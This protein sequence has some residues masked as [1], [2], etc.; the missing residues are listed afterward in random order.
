MESKVRKKNEVKSKKKNDKNEKNKKTEG[1]I[2]C[3]YNF[4]KYII[5]I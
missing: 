1:I 4:R 3:R 2:T 5:E